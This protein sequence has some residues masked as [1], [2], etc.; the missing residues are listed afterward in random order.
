MRATNTNSMCSGQIARVSRR[1]GSRPVG[2]SSR[3]RTTEPDRLVA[4]VARVNSSVGRTLAGSG[5]LGIAVFRK[6]TVTGH[7]PRFCIGF[8]D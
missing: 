3:A 2:T 4:P 1:P 6:V 7:L 5:Y 8:G